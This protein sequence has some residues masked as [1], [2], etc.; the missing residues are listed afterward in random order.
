MPLSAQQ[1]PALPPKIAV[2]EGEGAV[3]SIRQGTIQD[4]L[5]RV[6]DQE[7]RPLAGASLTFILPAS[8]RFSWSV[9]RTSRSCIVP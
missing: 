8:G 2:L 9:T 1:A 5:V 4:L 7:N 3:N 6:T